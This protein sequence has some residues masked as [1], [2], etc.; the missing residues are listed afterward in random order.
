MKQGF[1]PYE[2]DGRD[3]TSRKSM[4]FQI[5]NRF[6]ENLIFLNSVERGENHTALRLINDGQAVLFMMETAGFIAFATIC[7]TFVLQNI[8]GSTI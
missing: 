3:F 8:D 4:Q 2:T 7:T 1:C 5:F 6:K